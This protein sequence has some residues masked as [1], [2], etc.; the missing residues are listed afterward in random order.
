MD[1]IVHPRFP[2]Q[3]HAH[4]ILRCIEWPSSIVAYEN[5]VGACE[6]SR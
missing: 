2:A 1:D 6:R 3:R 5:S 4:L